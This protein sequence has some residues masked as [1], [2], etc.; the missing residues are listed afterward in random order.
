MGCFP[1]TGAQRRRILKAPLNRQLSHLCPTIL[2]CLSAPQ[3]V[4]L[5]EEEKLLQ[6]IC[7]RR[8][9]ILNLRGRSKSRSRIRVS[10]SEI[11]SSHWKD[12]TDMSQREVQRKSQYKWRATALILC[13]E[14]LLRCHMTDELM[15][16]NHSKDS[17]INFLCL[18]N[19]GGGK[20]DVGMFIIV[21]TPLLRSLF[22][23]CLLPRI[24]HGKNSVH[25]IVPK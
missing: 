19:M 23:K 1:E 24:Q 15:S 17:K 12:V 5:L 18:I 8:L 21:G 14:F 9:R 3:N 16:V 6:F 4:E 13:I 22:S 20:P 11:I 25:R 10:E 7:S 2:L